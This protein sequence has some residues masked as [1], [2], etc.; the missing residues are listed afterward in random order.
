M[1]GQGNET[2]T[3]V[4]NGCTA[5]PQKEYLKRH[6]NVCQYTHWRLCTNFDPETTK[7]WYENKPEGCVENEKMKVLCDFIIQCDREVIARK[8]DIILIDKENK[9][10]KIIDVAISGD[11]RV[12]EKEREKIDKYQPLHDEIARLWSMRKVEIISVGVGAFHVA[13]AVSEQF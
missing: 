9:L 12:L 6:N 13:G 7:H 10:T 4:V 3:H 11:A 5:L 8:P 1:G 2:V